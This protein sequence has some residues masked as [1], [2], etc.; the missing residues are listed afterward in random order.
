MAVTLIPHPLVSPIQKGLKKSTH[1]LKRKH[2]GILGSTG[3]I[4]RTTLAIVERFP[5]RFSVKA[6]GAGQNIDLLARQIARFKPEMAVVRDETLARQLKD[7]LPAGAKVAIRHGEQGYCEAASLDGVDLVVAAMVGA[8]GLTPTLAAIAAGKNVALANKET[9]VMAGAH[10]MAAAAA[11]GV[12]ILPVDSEHSAIF[13]CLAGNRRKDLARIILTGSGGPF[14][15]RPA[16]DFAAITVDQALNHPNWR[17]GPKITVDSATLMNKGLE[18]IEARWLFD[19]SPQAIEV[20]IHPQSIVHSMAVFTDGSVLA[21]MGVPDMTVAIG[22]ALAYPR[23]LALGVPVPDFAAL[24][25]LDFQPPDMAKFPCLALAVEACA[26]AGAYPAVLNAAN[27]VA[28]A[29]FL[30]GALGFD[31]I[32]GLIRAVMDAYKGSRA[33]ECLE[34]IWAADRWARREAKMKLET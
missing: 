12:K 25:T 15:L 24:A 4:G 19:L 30:A 2:L 3:S 14:R 10:V 6:L 9:L 26:R 31:R 21:Q 22:Y 13:Q 11:R 5:D 16:A 7:L 27:E 8:A 28:V 29:A 23:R 17:M 33:D 32:P 20:V 1:P 34:G 18:V